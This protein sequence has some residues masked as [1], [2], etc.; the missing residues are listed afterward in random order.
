MRL[1]AFQQEFAGRAAEETPDNSPEAGNA[2]QVMTVHQAKGLEFRVVFVPSLIQGR[3]PSSLTGA[4]QG[5][6]VPR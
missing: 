6:H 5:W 1:R 2:V 4:P 3:F